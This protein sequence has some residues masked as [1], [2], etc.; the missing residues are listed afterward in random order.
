M[1]GYPNSDPT[2]KAWSRPY[3]R[4]GYPEYVPVHCVRCGEHLYD[5]IPSTGVSGKMC[6]DCKAISHRFAQRKYREDKPL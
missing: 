1:K 3:S 6:K 5:Q 4:E 2:R